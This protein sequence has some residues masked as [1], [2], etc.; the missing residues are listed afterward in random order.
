MGKT[1]GLVLHALNLLEILQFLVEINF[2]A[3]DQSA[4]RLYGLVRSVLDLSLKTRS[5]LLHFSHIA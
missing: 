1:Q 5:S 3:R 4:L 2:Y